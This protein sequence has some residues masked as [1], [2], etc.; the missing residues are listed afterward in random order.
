M[1]VMLWPFSIMLALRPDYLHAAPSKS[2]DRLTLLGDLSGTSDFQTL[3]SRQRTPVGDAEASE[4]TRSAELA[5]KR[6]VTNPGPAQNLG[7]PL[8]FP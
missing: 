3:T 2:S 4:L 1:P 6:C 8:I 7:S 5:R